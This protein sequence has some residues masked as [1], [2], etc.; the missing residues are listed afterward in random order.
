[1][2]PDLLLAALLLMTPPGVPEAPPTAEVWP[3]VRDGVHQ[4]AVEWEILDPREVRYT[5]QSP[6][7]FAADLDMLRRRRVDLADTPR[8]ADG[9][10][11][12]ERERVNEQVRFN[13]SFRKKIEERAELESDRQPFFA[14]VV[15]E[16]DQ[17]YAVYDAV[18]DA[19]CA[20]YYVTVR[21][22]ALNKLRCLLGDDAYRAAEL[23]PVVPTWRFNDL[24]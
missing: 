1:M 21:R 7:Q 3:A 9:E 20:F 5:F 19:R 23:P 13:R 24:K 12:P 15:K 17:L 22:Q 16:T 18:R 8:V 6:E 2:K 14:A 10:R 11:F 4:V